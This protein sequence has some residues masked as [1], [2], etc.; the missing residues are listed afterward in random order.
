[1]SLLRLPYLPRHFLKLNLVTRSYFQAPSY[2]FTADFHTSK[3][4]YDMSSDERPTGLKA[5]KGIELLTFGTPNG[6][7]A[8]ILLEELKET[9]GKDFTW[10]SI[11][12]SQNI[13]KEEW[14]TKLGP[15]GRIPVIVDHD[16]GGFAVQEGLGECF[17][18]TL[19]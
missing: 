16:Q 18:S 8:S 1:M 6:W 10:Q 19:T 13:Q 12:I 14:F 15:N 5:N 9:Y 4:L 17:S 3:P 7:K 2:R 11:N